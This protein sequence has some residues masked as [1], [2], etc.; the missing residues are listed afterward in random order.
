MTFIVKFGQLTYSHG[1]L[2]KYFAT[3]AGLGPRSKPFLLIS[4]AQ[5]HPYFPIDM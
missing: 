2:T 3:L 4:Q 5:K 1:Q